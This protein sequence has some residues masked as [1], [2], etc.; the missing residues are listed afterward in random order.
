MIR[1]SAAIYKRVQQ[2]SAVQSA[3]KQQKHHQPVVSG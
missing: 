1:F 2:G 3:V